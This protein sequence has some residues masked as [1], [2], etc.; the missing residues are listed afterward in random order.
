MSSDS[1]DE[2][3]EFQLQIRV[4]S[5]VLETRGQVRD[6]PLTVRE[7]L[8]VLQTVTNGIVTSLSRQAEEAGKLISCKA[9]CG[10]CCCQPVPIGDA[11]ALMLIQLV[12]GMPEER[13]AAIR[14]RFA[15]ALSRL[16]E[17]GL[18][19]KVRA[20]P[21]L[22][23]QEDREKLALAYLALRIACPFLED[24]SCSIHPDRPLSCRE[25]LVTSPAEFCSNPDRERIAMVDVPRRLSALMVREM[26]PWLPLILAFEA[27][28]RLRAC[29]EPKFPAK[30]LVEKVVRYLGGPAAPAS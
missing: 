3:L 4:G 5:E 30:E 18:L 7:F 19:E 23:S 13:R 20:F 14:A 12:D 22:P 28:E 10:A 29:P 15:A 16:E 26:T 9:G 8:P 2:I 24:D 17:A 11:E 21:A 25:Y 27:A 1:G 6:G